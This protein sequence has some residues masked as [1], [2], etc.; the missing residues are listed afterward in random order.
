MTHK[1]FRFFWFWIH[2]NTYYFFTMLIH[3]RSVIVD[4]SVEI[5]SRFYVLYRVL[6]SSL[7][8]DTKIRW[9]L[10]IPGTL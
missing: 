1:R 10:Y 8:E 2:E 5:S 4:S 9:I 6:Y 7:Y 3:F